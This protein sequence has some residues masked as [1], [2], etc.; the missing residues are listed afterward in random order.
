MSRRFVP[1]IVGLIVLALVVVQPLSAEVVKPA[2]TLDG[3]W[4]QKQSKEAKFATILNMVDAATYGYFSGYERGLNDAAKL[5]PNEKSQIAAL[6]DKNKPFE[7]SHSIPFYISVVDM[8]YSSSKH[9]EIPVVYVVTCLAD[10]TLLDP[11]CKPYGARRPLPT[12]V[13]SR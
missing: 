4:W 11:T 13:S 1:W 6:I 7:F 8:Y 2:F 10:Q 12:P 3:H 5:A 9:L